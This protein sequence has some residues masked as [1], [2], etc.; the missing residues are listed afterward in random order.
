LRYSRHGLLEHDGQ[1]VAPGKLHD[2]NE[3]FRS[4][5]CAPWEKR[6]KRRSQKAINRLVGGGWLFKKGEKKLTP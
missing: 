3:L 6:S 1:S 4:Y 2:V 5:Y